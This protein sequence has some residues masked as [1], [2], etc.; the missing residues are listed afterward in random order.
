MI[1]FLLTIVLIYWLPAIFIGVV[2]IGVA[3]ELYN[4]HLEDYAHKHTGWRDDKK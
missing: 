2:V 4:M 3:I 1:T